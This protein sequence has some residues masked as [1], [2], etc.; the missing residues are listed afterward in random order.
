MK[1]V[2]LNF[3]RGIVKLNLDLRKKKKDENLFAVQEKYA[4]KNL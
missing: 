3:H 4:L 1:K 2:A